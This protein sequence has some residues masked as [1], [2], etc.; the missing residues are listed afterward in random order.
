MGEV[1][2]DQGPIVGNLKPGTVTDDVRPELSGKGKPGQHR[3]HHGWRRCTGPTVVDPDGNWTF[4]PE[5]D[6]ADGDHS[7]TV[8][9][10]DPAGNEVTSPSFDITVDATA[11]E[12]PVLGSA[13][14]DVG[15]IRGDLSNGGTTDDA[16]PT[17]N[18]SAEPGSRVDIYDNGEHIG[19]TIADDNGAWQFTPTTP[20]PEG[21]HH[22]TTTATD[23]AGNTGPESD[24]FVLVTDYTPT[25]GKQ[26]CTE[27]Y[28]RNG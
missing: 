26:R 21:E 14:D 3:D 4:T 13:T 15:T 8:I 28:V 20:L 18:G 11:P 7:L 24:D 19:S 9:S 16:N 5:Q 27:H 25:S 12:K 10:K 6:L 2:D 17:F 22:I 1:V 23:E